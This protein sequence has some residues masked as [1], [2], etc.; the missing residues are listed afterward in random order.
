[1]YPKEKRKRGLLGKVNTEDVLAPLAW[2]PICGDPVLYRVRET[3]ASACEAGESGGK[4]QRNRN[5]STYVIT[6]VVALAGLICIQVLNTILRI[7]N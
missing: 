5:D 1:M 4:R 2:T 7:M 3:E 6:S